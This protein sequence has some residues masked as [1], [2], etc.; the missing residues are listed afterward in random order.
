MDFLKSGQSV[1]AWT[2]FCWLGWVP[3]LNQDVPTT[4]RSSQPRETTDKE[5]RKE[6]FYFTTHSTHFIYGYVVSTD[7]EEPQKEHDNTG[8]PSCQ[9]CIYM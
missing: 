5:G 3:A 4:G 6:I 9:L 2:R 1:A 7:N 8:V